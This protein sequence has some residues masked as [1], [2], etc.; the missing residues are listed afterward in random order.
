MTENNSPGSLK[1]YM[2]LSIVYTLTGLK[3]FRNDTKEQLSLSYL[4]EGGTS[5][6]FFDRPP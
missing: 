6:L 3:V 5:P 4:G 1:K 2:S